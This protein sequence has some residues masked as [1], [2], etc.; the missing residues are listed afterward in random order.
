[1]PKIVVIQATQ[2]TCQGGPVFPGALKVLGYI[3]DLCYQEIYVMA[4]CKRYIPSICRCIGDASSPSRGDSFLCYMQMQPNI[5]V[6]HPHQSRLE[7]FLFLN[8]QHMPKLVQLTQSCI[9]L[10]RWYFHEPMRN[11]PT[12]GTPCVLSRLSWLAAEQ[13]QRNRF[14]T[15]C[16]RD[17]NSST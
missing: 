9:L 8:H 14:P 10:C 16:N 15:L 2:V 7:D 1:M 12:R 6:R 11:W 13:G 4:I 5:G 17:Y 3:H